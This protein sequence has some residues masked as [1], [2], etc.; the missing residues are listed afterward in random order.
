MTTCISVRKVIDFLCLFWCSCNILA[1]FRTIISYANEST[2][3][4]LG[5]EVS[6]N[7]NMQ[8][9]SDPTEIKN[10]GVVGVDPSNTFEDP[11]VHAADL[12]APIAGNK[13]TQQAA[14]VTNA[15]SDSSDNSKS[16]DDIYQGFIESS[17]KRLRSTGENAISTQDSRNGLK[18]SD[19]SAFTRYE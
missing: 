16:G 9:K 5:I 19:S 7:S 12:I 13:D 2:G 14:G 15:P 4:D 18:H 10:E 17:L 3:K 1:V 8:C 11:T 6:R